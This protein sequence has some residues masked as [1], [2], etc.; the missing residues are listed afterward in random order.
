VNA[1]LAVRALRERE[2]LRRVDPEH[3]GLAAAVHEHVVADLEA[4]G[5]PYLAKNA[6]AT[7]CRPRRAPASRCPR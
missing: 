7:A 2:R 1:V 3:R 6:S 4:P 5:S